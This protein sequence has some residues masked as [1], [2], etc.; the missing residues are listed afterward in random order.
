MIRPLV[1]ACIMCLA[2]SG[3]YDTKTMFPVPARA[4]EVS[5]VVMQP[6]V[7]EQ[8]HFW[9]NETY[10]GASAMEHYSGLFATWRVCEWSDKGWSSF[11]DSSQREGRFIHQFVH[12]WLN[13]RGDTAVTVA[14]RYT[15]AGAEHRARPESD[16]QFVAVVRYKAPDA[17]T[18]LAQIGALCPARR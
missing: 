14:L 16:R 2:L 1:V 17:A 7:W 9:L 5:H 3:C 6:D 18:H 13:D 12:Y 10:L 4:E 15:S 11:G 8:D